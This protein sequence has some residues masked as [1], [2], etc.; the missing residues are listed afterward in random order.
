MGWNSANGIASMYLKALAEEYGF[1][2]DTPWR[3]LPEEIR[4]VILYGTGGKKI[5]VEYERDYGGGF[6]KRHSKA[7]YPLLKDVITKL[8]PIP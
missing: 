8:N 3:E 1:S 2:P 5:H 7:L 4:K 6:S